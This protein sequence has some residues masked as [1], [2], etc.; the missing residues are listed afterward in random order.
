LYQEFIKKFSW[1]WWVLPVSKTKGHPAPFTPE[2]VVRLI[3]YCSF[4]GETVLD[5]FGGS[6][7][8]MKVARD[9]ERDSIIYENN[10]PFIELIKNNVKWYNATLYNNVTFE[11]INKSNIC[12]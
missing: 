8:T 5:P 4:P 2:L 12:L 6:G 3:K 1:S 10:P 7:T 11:L 9:L